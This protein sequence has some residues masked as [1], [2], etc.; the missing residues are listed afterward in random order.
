MEIKSYYVM[1]CYV[2]TDLHLRSLLQIKVVKS[3]GI[4]NVFSLNLYR[5][6]TNLFFQLQH[7][8]SCISAHFNGI[9]KSTQPPY[10][11]HTHTRKTLDSVQKTSL[12][13]SFFSLILTHLLTH[14]SRLPSSST[15][16]CSISS[17]FSI[18]GENMEHIMD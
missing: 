1:H 4:L 18:Y 15:S 11:H 17:I 12:D 3:F 2:G 8:N 5:S 14:C 9:V 13:S 7:L 6:N 10:T 16:F